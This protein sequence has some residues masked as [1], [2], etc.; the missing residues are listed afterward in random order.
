MA[1]QMDD[2]EIRRRLE[3][4]MRR[5]PPTTREVFLAHRLDDM[6]YS[7]IAEHTGLSARDIERHMTRAIIAIDRSLNEPPLRWWERWFR[8]RSNPPL[9]AAHDKERGGSGVRTE[10][11]VREVRAGSSSENDHDPVHTAQQID[12]FTEER[13]AQ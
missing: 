6:S 11:R 7:E 3:R 2:P 5:V 8:W 9:G 13:A 4:A 10:Q 1:Q 12:A